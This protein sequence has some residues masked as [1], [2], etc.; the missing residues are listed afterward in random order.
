MDGLSLPS[1]SIAFREILERQF[2]EEEIT[3]ALVDCCGDK[4]PGPDSMTMAFLQ[5]N[6]DLVREEVLNMFWSFT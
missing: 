2:D 3:K 5:A 4:A 1:L 6:W